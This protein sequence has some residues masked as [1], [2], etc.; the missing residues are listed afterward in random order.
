MSQTSDHAE[1]V[2][3]QSAPPV[4]VPE[5]ENQS[6]LDIYSAYL[7][8]SGAPPVGINPHNLKEKPQGEKIS[9]PIVVGAI[10]IIVLMLLI[11]FIFEG[12]SNDSYLALASYL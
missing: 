12:L 5:A 2:P 8:P 10:S 1:S 6:P 3:D 9:V 11:Y 4:T 7:P